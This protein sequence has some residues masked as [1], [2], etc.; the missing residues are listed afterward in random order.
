MHIQNIIYKFSSDMS[1]SKVETL[2]RYLPSSIFQKSTNCD[3]ISLHFLIIIGIFPGNWLVLVAY[4]IF[5]FA[6]VWSKKGSNSLTKDPFA[7]IESG[8]REP[9]YS[10]HAEKI[11]TL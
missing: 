9:I 8:K 7:K 5:S 3:L 2:D 11:S 10:K 1:R 4:L 6:Q